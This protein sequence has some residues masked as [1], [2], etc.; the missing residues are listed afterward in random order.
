MARYKII[1]IDLETPQLSPIDISGGNAMAICFVR[2]MP[3]AQGS[4]HDKLGQDFLQISID[5]GDYFPIRPFDKIGVPPGSCQGFQLIRYRVLRGVAAWAHIMLVY[6]MCILGLGPREEIMLPNKSRTGGNIVEAIDY[7]GKVAI[8]ATQQATVLSHS[9]ADNG[10]VYLY[11]LEVWIDAA[12]NLV[13][14]FV[15]LKW[16]NVVQKTWLMASAAAATGTIPLIQGFYPPLE[17]CQIGI[18][19]VDLLINVQNL[20]SAKNSAFGASWTLGFE[21]GYANWNPDQELKGH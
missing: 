5:G 8:L 4:S 14:Y 3:K 17:F 13:H 10:I 9:F 12:T 7:S 15:R 21:N 6:D 11:D 20:D 18:G 1:Q 19:A 16:N 2:F